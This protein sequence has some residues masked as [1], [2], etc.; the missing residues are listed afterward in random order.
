MKMGNRRRDERRLAAAQLRDNVLAIVAHD[1]RTPL[2][3]IIMAANLLA[4]I[5]EKASR[6][7]FLEM[8]LK[9][10]QQADYLIHDLVDATRI[11]NDGLQ[12]KCSSE[13][14]AYLVQSVVELFGEAAAATGI[15]L[16]CDVAAL[17]H[18]HL[19]VENPRFVQLLSNLIDN[20]IKFTPYGGTILVSARITN[21]FIEV[22]VADDGI[23][24][25]LDELPH[26]FERFWQANH[27]H[28]AGAGLGLAIAKGI[29]EAHG[30]QIGVRSKKGVGSTFF[31]TVPRVANPLACPTALES[32]AMV[33]APA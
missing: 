6:E 9:A 5:E 10:A 7:H 21:G 26:V 14:A 3:T 16:R 2:S 12:V 25:D 24:I 27:H 20:A 18:E 32:D 15:T 8:I 19:K 23:G 1:L 13:P 29:A 31:F 33:R 30:G 17:G 22:S 28:R 11:E 4:E